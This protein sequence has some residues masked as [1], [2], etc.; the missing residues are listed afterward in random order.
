MYLYL[1][2]FFFIVILFFLL[3]TYPN[4]CKEFYRSPLNSFMFQEPSVTYSADDVNLWVLKPWKSDGSRIPCHLMQHE[5]QDTKDATLLIYSHGNAE[6]LQHARILQRLLYD[7]LHLDVL[8]YDYPGYGLNVYDID[9]RN[10]QG[11]NKT[12]SAIVEHVV[13]VKGYQ[14]SNII[15]MSYSLGTGPSLHNVDKFCQ[16]GKCPKAVVTLGAFNSIKSVV[17]DHVGQTMSD[18]FEERW[19]CIEYMKTIHSNKVPTLIIHGERDN[20]I[21]VEH[22]KSFYKVN[23]DAKLVLSPTSGHTTLVYS[24]I[25]QSLKDWLD[26]STASMN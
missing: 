15:F 1:F 26:Q 20:L 3:W 14:M 4:R 11:L 25:V 13:N 10:A 24:P 9:E 19:N 12:L 6:N 17:R 23:P 21:P 16:A 2:V 7:D 5:Q 22:A 18:L 8:V